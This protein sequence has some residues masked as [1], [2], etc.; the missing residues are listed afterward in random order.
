M[1]LKS[2]ALTKQ[3]QVF[4]DEYMKH[5]DRER[6]EQEACYRPRFG[7]VVLARPEIQR[8]ITAQEV[9]KLYS[10]GLPAAVS[11]LIEIAKGAKYPAAA[12][13]QAAKA[14]MDRTLGA[15]GSGPA[16]ELHEMTPEEIAQ[17]IANLEAQASAAAVDVT[18]S[19]P[20]DVFG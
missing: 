9:G 20:V 2:G 1:P 18:P 3:E 13:V 15:D 16:K 14:I 10:E 17:A 6:A 4:L 19:G 11:T 7:Y 12:R 5:G 8:H